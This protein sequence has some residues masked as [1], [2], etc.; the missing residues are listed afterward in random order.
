M[1][2]FIDKS[3]IINRLKSALNIE[4]DSDL[5]SFL[6]IKP[7]TL[8]NWKTRNNIDYDLI[9]TKCESL[10][11]HW[12]ITGIER[13]LDLQNKPGEIEK[14]LLELLNEKDLQIKELKKALSATNY[15]GNLAA[16]PVEKLKKGK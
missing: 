2:N 3:L 14:R 12:L 5:A 6:G 15:Y 1:G 8:S 16:E 13:K 4:N 10:D 7:N 11:F 9:F